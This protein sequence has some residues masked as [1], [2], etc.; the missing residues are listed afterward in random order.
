MENKFHKTLMERTRS[1]L[2]K[3]TDAFSS[4]SSYKNKYENIT[5][6]EFKNHLLI[7]KNKNH[8]KL[9]Y[10]ILNT[11]HHVLDSGY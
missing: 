6:E 5:D 3:T 2:L 11:L 1:D 8:F 9:V 4:S 7:G 10:F